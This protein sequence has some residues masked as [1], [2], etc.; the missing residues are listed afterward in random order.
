[1]VRESARP[2]RRP[3][4][5]RRHARRG[6][7][8][9]LRRA[10]PPELPRAVGSVRTRGAERRYLA[11]RRP[12]R[13]C[14]APDPAGRA[15]GSPPAA[16]GQRRRDRLMRVLVTGGAGFVGSNVVGVA[17]ER[18]NEV[19]AVVRSLPPRPDPRCRYV[20]LDLLD[21]ESVTSAVASIRP[22]AI[23]H[24]AIWNDFAGIYADRRRAWESYVGVTRTLADSTRE[25]GAA[26]VT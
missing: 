18:G 13:P 24:T 14:A 20:A 21:A 16:A 5:G 22:D 17:A 25:T 2:R 4:D 10:L 1:G 3:P 6:P 12:R 23:V 9:L 11:R 8:V 15:A 7:P 19:A 26:L